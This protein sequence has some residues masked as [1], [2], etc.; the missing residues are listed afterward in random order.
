MN[1]GVDGQA[2]AEVIHFSSRAGGPHHRHILRRPKEPSP[3]EDPSPPPGEP[4]A[5]LA[6]FDDDSFAVS[7]RTWT[8]AQ[9]LSISQRA[10]LL[11]YVGS[12][13][14]AAAAAAHRAGPSRHPP[15]SPPP[16]LLCPMAA[17]LPGLPPCLCSLPCATGSRCVPGWPAPTWMPSTQPG[18]QTSWCQRCGTCYSLPVPPAPSC[19]RTPAMPVTAGSHECDPHLLPRG[20]HCSLQPL[21]GP[22]C[23]TCVRVRLRMC[24][25]PHTHHPHL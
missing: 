10:A 3:T 20:T 17:C 6:A 22:P 4:L 7:P 19:H 24:A 16:P 2:E 1:Q 9:V 25:S 14:A 13:G 12:A 5:A 11:T 21:A 23:L 18:T 8:A 15:D